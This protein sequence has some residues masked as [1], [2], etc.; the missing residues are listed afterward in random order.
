VTITE[1]SVHISSEHTDVVVDLNNV[2]KVFGG[3]TSAPVHALRG[4]DLQVKRHE[5]IAIVGP[6]GSGKSTLLN[7]LGCLDIP[8]GGTYR[9]NGTDV[10]SL[11]DSGRAAV[12]GRE[13]GFVF[14]QF[15]LLAH[16]SVMDNVELGSVYGTTSVRPKKRKE[17]LELAQ[18]ALQRVGLSH[19]VN[20]IAKT[21]SGGEKQRVAIARAIADQPSLLLADEPTGNLDSE[22]TLSVLEAF[23][24][25]RADGLTLITITHDLSVA[26]RFERR[27]RIA[28]GILTNMTHE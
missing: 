24:R 17:R 28:D 20:A 15:H 10:S 21:L 23:D 13:I 8:S 18:H 7:I 16:R 9:L 19:R 1:P 2:S 11:S 26:K 12:R 6:S 14:Q 27:V 5:T 3:K 4:V 22:N 25:L